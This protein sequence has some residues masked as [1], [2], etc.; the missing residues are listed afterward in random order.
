MRAFQS[1]MSACGARETKT[2]VVS[3]AYARHPAA[4]GGERVARAGELLLLDEEVAA[5]GL[6]LLR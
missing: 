4:L 6:P 3:R 1:A 5:R 2:S